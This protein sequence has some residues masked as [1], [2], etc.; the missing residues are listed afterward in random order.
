MVVNENT[1]TL[2]LIG[3]AASC[4]G[5]LGC[6]GNYPGPCR[7]CRIIYLMHDLACW[8]CFSSVFWVPDCVPE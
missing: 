2:E 3:C 6:C 4:G 7:R 8:S 1:Q 5:A